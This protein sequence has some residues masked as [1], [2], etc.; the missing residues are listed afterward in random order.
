MVA[1]ASTERYVVGLEISDIAI[2][3]AEE[4]TTV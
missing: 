2:K 4:V 3:K 1:M